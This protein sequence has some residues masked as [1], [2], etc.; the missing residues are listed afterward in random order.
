MVKFPEGALADNRLSYIHVAAEINGEILLI[1]VPCGSLIDDQETPKVHLYNWISREWRQIPASGDVP[2]SFAYIS[3]LFNPRV[4]GNLI[5][6]F[7]VDQGLKGLKGNARDTVICIP[8]EMSFLFIMRMNKK[9]T[10]LLSFF[11][12]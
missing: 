8:K 9:D 5:H 4:P 3:C 11:S 12:D 1:V 2:S 10:F 6:A 7:V